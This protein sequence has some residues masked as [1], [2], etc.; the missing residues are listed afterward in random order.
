MPT[1]ILVWALAAVAA[2]NV[3]HQRQQ[4]S[5]APSDAFVLRLHVDDDCTLTDQ[6]L[7]TVRQG[8]DEYGE[9][10]W[11]EALIDRDRELDAAEQQLVEAIRALPR[12]QIERVGDDPRRREAGDRCWERIGT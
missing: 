1:A 12:T 3:W 8:L 6:A 4:S 9:R 7:E 11:V 10:M 5:P 2:W